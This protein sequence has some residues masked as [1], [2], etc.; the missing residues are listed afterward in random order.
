MNEGHQRGWRPRCHAVDKMMG[1]LPPGDFPR[2]IRKLNQKIRA[3][4]D[5]AP[6][7]LASRVLYS[8]LDD[9]RRAAKDFSQVIE[10]A[11]RCADALHLRS[12]CRA[13]LGEYRLAAEDYD[14]IIQ[15]DPHDAGAHDSC[16]VCRMNLGEPDRVMD[17]DNNTVI[18]LDPSY[19][20]PYYNR[21]RLQPGEHY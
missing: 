14:A 18:G 21:A 3:S 6:S 16:A 20:I 10:L 17:N 9:D 1:R 4:P 12:V 8:K 11:P 15:L 2:G 13:G 19:A 7:L 5:N